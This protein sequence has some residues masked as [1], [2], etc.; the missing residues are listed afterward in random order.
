MEFVIIIAMLALVQYMAFGML[1]GRARGKFGV[2]APATTGHPEFERY[3]RAHYNTLEQLVIFLPA[4]L[5]A[6]YLGNELVAVVAGAVFLIGRSLYFRTYVQDA[7]KR[8][9]GMLLTFV[10]NIVLV[11][12]ALIGAALQAF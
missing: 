11:L 1:V 5:A 8:G 12:T 3:F 4:L 9:P 7:A 10:S 2:E 6:G